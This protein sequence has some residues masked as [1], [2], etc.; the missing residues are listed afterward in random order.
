VGYHLRRAI[1]EIGDFVKG[2]P[3]SDGEYCFTNSKMT[4]GVV[5]SIDSDMI[6]V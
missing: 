3:E 6:T 1:M 4:R 5:V 2:K